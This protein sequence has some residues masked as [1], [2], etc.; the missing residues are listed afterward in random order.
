MVVTIYLRCCKDFIG[1]PSVESETKPSNPSVT[2]TRIS[3]VFQTEIP[4]AP[5]TEQYYKYLVH[6]RVRE[7][8]EWR[9][10]RPLV[11][12]PDGATTTRRVLS[13]TINNLAADTEYEI[14]VAVCRVWYG[15]RGECALAAD[16]VVSV[17]TGEKSTSIRT[18]V[19]T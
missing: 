3:F 5:G 2:S 18:L 16:P 10:S 11:D 12:H 15:V 1:I 14:Q 8:V 6:Y 4:V 9:E 17:R 19:P 13:H 7:S